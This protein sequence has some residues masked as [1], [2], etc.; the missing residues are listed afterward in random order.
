V[1]AGVDNRFLDDAS[2]LWLNRSKTDTSRLT[3]VDSE[4]YSDWIEAISLAI[5]S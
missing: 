2:E 5:N 1:T 3:D 4:S